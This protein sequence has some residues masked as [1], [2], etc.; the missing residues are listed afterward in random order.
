MTTITITPA[1]PSIPSKRFR[2]VSGNLRSEG[3]T[4]GQALDELTAR[5]PAAENS[6]LIVLQ[7]FRPDRFFNA[8]QQ[9]RLQELML[10][11]H[12]ARDTG[13]ALPSDEQAEL[14]SLVE[15]E[16]R[17]ACERARELADGMKP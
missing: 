9:R 15:A 3:D 13:T 1:D 6:A 4:A 14:D 12:A 16:L 5:L 8:A 11:W 10:R 7:S 17:A 2:A